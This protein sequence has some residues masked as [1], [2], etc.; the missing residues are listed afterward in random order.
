[1]K[2]RHTMYNS[3]N[4]NETH[5]LVLKE[6]RG[7]LVKVTIPIEDCSY[8]CSDIKIANPDSKQAILNR[9]LKCLKDYYP[10]L[11][12]YS[13]VDS[14][15]C[16]AKKPDRS[17]GTRD[18]DRYIHQEKMHEAFQKAEN[19]PSVKMYSREAIGWNGFTYE[20][21]DDIKICVSTNFGYGMSSYF[22]LTASYKDIVIAPITDLVNYYKAQMVDII[23]CTRPYWPLRDSWHPA[24]DF[25]QSFA[26]QSLSNPEQFVKTYIM[27]E[28]DKLMRGLRNI[29]MNPE[30]VIGMFKR[31]MN[32]LP[33]E[34]HHLRFIEPMS[35][36]E[37]ECYD[38]FPIDMP[39]VFKSEK[40]IGAIEMMEK[41]KELTAIYAKISDYINE[42]IGMVN[43]LKPEVEEAIE[44]MQVE[45]ALLDEYRSFINQQQTIKWKIDSVSSELNQVL[46]QNATEA[47]DVTIEEIVARFN[48][49]HEQLQDVENQLQEIAKKCEPLMKDKN[50]ECKSIYTLIEKIK[51]RIADRVNVR[52][53]LS[54]FIDLYSKHAVTFENVG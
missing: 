12:P 38:L 18:Y 22:K 52:N 16:G 25:V 24:L 53:R 49:L 8:I 21:T 43:Q 47:E 9:K 20:I 54:T 29:M 42:I 2:K 48:S 34:Y 11:Y 32:H 50:E 30:E 17:S 5:V 41:L 35:D 15:I 44:R 33:E 6:E 3:S 40:L 31:E 46:L 19:D 14:Y 10:Y 23:S 39:I 26:N 4:V 28:V 13:Y 36:K 51:S 27:N 45:I 1:M 37:K 7:R